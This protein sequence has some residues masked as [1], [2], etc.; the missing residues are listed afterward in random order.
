MREIGQ[1]TPSDTITKPVVLILLGPPGAGGKGTQA[2]MLEE[3]FGLVQLSTGIC[4]ALRLRRAACGI[5]GE[6]GD[7]SG[8][9]GLG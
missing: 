7:G 8:R 2:R 4:C 1:T 3:R 6:I 9:S 5:G